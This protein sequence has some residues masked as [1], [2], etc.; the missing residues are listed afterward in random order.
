VEKAVF[1]YLQMENGMLKMNTHG[2]IERA[3]TY[4]AH[5]NL[6]LSGMLISD[7]T[8]DKDVF[9]GIGLDAVYVFSNGGMAPYN[10][11]RHGP[12]LTR[13]IQELD[14]HALIGASG[15]CVDELFPWV[16]AAL[17]TTML[18]HV[19]RADK[20]RFFFA[21]FGGKAMV[22]VKYNGVGPY[23]FSC[24]LSGK[25]GKKTGGTTP[26]L[27][28]RQLP[29]P[30]AAGRTIRETAADNT[31]LDVS[32][33]GFVVS[34]GRGMKTR[35]GFALLAK[36]AEEVGGAVGATRAAVDEGLAP[37]YMQVGQTGKTICPDI[38]VA[39]GISGAVQHLAGMAGSRVVV[40]IN[41]DPQAPIFQHA[42]YG[43]VG[44]ATPIL[45]EMNNLK[46]GGA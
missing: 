22:S 42:T 17:G 30:E 34:G 8:P 41:T 23:L 2:L 28:E 31:H 21:A 33:A 11:N 44:D 20:D 4:A 40:A 46:G 3:A 5:W 32:E 14:I 13:I 9:S 39:C 43:V 26:V 7:Q 36:L 12:A 19:L 27:I 45:K 15:S 25:K 16:S 1:V 29:D 35:E 10:V 24:N 6:P 37:Q 38:Y 18:S